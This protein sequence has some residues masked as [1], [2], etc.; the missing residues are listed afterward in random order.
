MDKLQSVLAHK[1]WILFV[2]VLIVTPIAWS[3]GTGSLT[4]GIAGEKTKLEGRFKKIDGL[5]STAGEK[6]DLCI[7]EL[8]KN[9]AT[10][11]SRTTDAAA[12]LWNGQKRLKTWPSRISRR[13]PDFFC[14]KAKRC[15]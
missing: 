14:S 15:F 1:F 13:A 7:E 8:S 12:Q 3:I 4:E 5:V 11:S 6:N 10:M 9:N 2:T